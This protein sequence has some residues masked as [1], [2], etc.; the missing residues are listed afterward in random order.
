MKILK[1]ITLSIFIL[2]AASSCTKE[3]YEEYYND[4]YEESWHVKEFEILSN[5]WKLV[6]EPDQIGSYYEYIFDKVPLEVSYY[7]GV[8]TAYIFFD[9]KSKNET[10]TPLPYT[11]Y[12]ID[13]TS[14]E[15]INYSVQYSYYVKANGT[16]AFTAHVSDY[17]TSLFNPGTQYF[18]LA[19]V[20]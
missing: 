13:A 2:I 8:V 6:G 17:Y 3:Y 19:I 16:I 7:D 12:L 11:E 14:G 9:Y 1:H 15:E 20:W 10:Q 18:R 5:H 4:V